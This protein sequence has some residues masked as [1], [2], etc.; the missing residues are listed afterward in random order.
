MGGPYVGVCHLGVC[1]VF[2]SCPASV[3]KR[4]SG[5]VPRPLAILAGFGQGESCCVRFWLCVVSQLALSVWFL[6][7][8]FLINWTNFL[9][10]Q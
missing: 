3:V 1:V 7:P 2:S 8:V 9:P 6:G 4:S 10:I 5:S